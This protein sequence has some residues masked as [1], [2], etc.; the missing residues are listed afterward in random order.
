MPVVS[1][2]YHEHYLWNDGELKAKCCDHVG[3]HSVHQRHHRKQHKLCTAQ[4]LTY[5]KVQ[6]EVVLSVGI[7]K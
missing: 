3:E 2:Q 6:G 1:T 4:G 5:A 7:H